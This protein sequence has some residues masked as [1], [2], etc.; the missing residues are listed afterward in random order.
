[1][2]ARILAGVGVLLYALGATSTA[3]DDVVKVQLWHVLVAIPAVVALVR[4]WLAW[5]RPSLSGGGGKGLIA[6]WM[7]LLCQPKRRGLHH[8]SKY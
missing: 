5:H 8:Q 2:P 1:M 7:L 6:M 4:A 3:R